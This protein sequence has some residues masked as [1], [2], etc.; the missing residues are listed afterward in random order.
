MDTPVVSL[1]CRSAD[2]Q[3]DRQA[4]AKGPVLIPEH[5]PGSAP[6]VEVP[7][8]PATT[9]T[10]SLR[11]VRQVADV[12]PYH[13][14]PVAAPIPPVH[15]TVA[16]DDARVPLWGPLKWVSRLRES[17]RAWDSRHPQVLCPGHYTRTLGVGSFRS[18]PMVVMRFYT[19]AW[20]TCTVLC[21]HPSSACHCFKKDAFCPAE[22]L[23]SAAGSG[24]GQQVQSRCIA[25]RG[26]Q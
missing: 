19:D 24:V 11:T 26:G 12:C 18:Q 8:H 16:R 20:D 21:T 6:S 4:R 10:Q 17:R 7:S 9:F 1:R 2:L 22:P 5:E 23:Q 25:Q 13:N 3:Q 15:I 14:V